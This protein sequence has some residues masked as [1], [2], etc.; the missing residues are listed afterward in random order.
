[1][2]FATEERTLV[3]AGVGA[4]GGV[5][6]AVGTTMTWFTIEIGDIASPGGS[7]TGMEG[8]D[9]WTVVACAVAALVAAAL[10]VLQRNPMAAK[11]LFLAAGCITTVVAIAGILDATSKDHEVEEAFGIPADRVSASVGAG[12]WFVALGGISELAAGALSKATSDE[13][14]PEPVS[15][16][17]P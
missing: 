12:L 13:T 8:R 9:G 15:A 3:I 7:A 17:D 4:L 2:K 6:A 16:T 1:V 10:V 14:E 5:L 11:V